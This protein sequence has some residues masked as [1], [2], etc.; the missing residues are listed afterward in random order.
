VLRNTWAGGG[1]PSATPAGITLSAVKDRI[2]PGPLAAGQTGHRLA[3]VTSHRPDARRGAAVSDEGEAASTSPCRHAHDAT[4][5]LTIP[6]ASSPRPGGY[7]VATGARRLTRDS[8]LG[9][10]T[11][12]SS[13]V[14]GT[15]TA[16]PAGGDV[17]GLVILAYIWFRFGNVRYGWAGHRH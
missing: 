4:T 11:S 17:R 12:F 9:S 10:V 2:G 8:S 1:G 6:P 16:R 14:S 3:G 5:N 15:M 7:A 13:Q